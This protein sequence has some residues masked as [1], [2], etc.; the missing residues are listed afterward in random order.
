M[1]ELENQYALINKIIANITSEKI[2]NDH[3][4]H[5]LLKELTDNIYLRLIDQ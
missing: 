5:K 1:I 2:L 3:F 4:N